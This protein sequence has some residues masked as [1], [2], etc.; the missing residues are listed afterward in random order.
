[1]GTAL[2]EH[3]LQ[4]FPVGEAA[5]YGGNFPKVTQ[6]QEVACLSR[7]GTRAVRFDRSSLRTYVPPPLPAMLDQGFEQ[8]VPKSND[9]EPAPLSDVLAAL[10]HYKVSTAARIVTYRN[11]LN[12]L[13]LT[14][15][16]LQD[17]WEMLVERDTNGR[18]LLHVR[19]TARKQAEEECRSEM[20]Q[21]MCYWGYRF[22]QLCTRPHASNSCAHSA[23]AVPVPDTGG[24]RVASPSDPHSYTNLFDS[25]EVA[26]L[27]QRYARCAST[28]S[29]PSSAAVNANEE[30]CA[31]LSLGLAQHKLLMAAEMDC[32]SQ[33][34][35]EGY[36]ELKTNKLL[37]EPRDRHNFEKFKL[38]R[39]WLQSF[40]AGVPTIVVGFRDAQ[41][42]VRE[43]SSLQTLRIHRMVREKNF[44][45]PTVCL[46]FGRSVLD[47]LAHSLTKL[48]A[49]SVCL[50]RYEPKQR[51]ITLG[52]IGSRDVASKA[53]PSASAELKRKRE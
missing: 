49:S 26:T 24:S 31:I 8:Y 43:I 6:P 17:D 41:G 14:P 20:Q 2:S 7:D 18:I 23:A 53:T 15:F 29:T 39:I 50:L 45:D 10:A 37:I 11:N 1:M 28:P 47:W 51:E 30:F 52:V 3:V 4:R 33:E 32:V 40:L 42:V 46:N 48:D 36:V 21:R 12:K 9:G 19:D 16:S 25:A 38:L 5:Q 44:W 27:R 13:M 35:S 34:Q 22:E